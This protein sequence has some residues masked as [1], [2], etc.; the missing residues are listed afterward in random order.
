MRQPG[1]TMGIG[2]GRHRRIQDIMVDARIPASQRA[3]WPVVATQ[4]QVIWVPGV[5]IDPT[6]VVLPDQTAVHLSVI[7][8]DD[9][10]NFGYD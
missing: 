1:E 8:S 5:R 10:D 3:N 7:R 4:Q 6:F 9:D 2:H